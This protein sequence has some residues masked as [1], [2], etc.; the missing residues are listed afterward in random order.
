MLHGHF[1]HVDKP[2]N[3]LAQDDKLWS[4][5]TQDSPHITTQQY[6]PTWSVTIVI[7][8]G[9]P[10]AAHYFNPIDKHPPPVLQWA[11]AHVCGLLIGW[12]AI[13]IG[14]VSVLAMGP[15]HQL[16]S[17][18]GEVGVSI[19][20]DAG[21]DE[22]SKSELHC[23]APEWGLTGCG[24]IQG[25]EVPLEGRDN[26]QLFK[27]VWGGFRW[28]GIGVKCK[29]FLRVEL[30]CSCSRKS[31]WGTGRKKCCCWF[32]K[33]CW[34]LHIHVKYICWSSQTTQNVWH[35][36]YPK[37]T[38]STIESAIRGMKIPHLDH[39][40]YP[41]QCSSPRIIST[42]TPACNVV[43]KVNIDL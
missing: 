1:S 22:S 23:A 9:N 17:L 35:Q 13:P 25:E 39:Q 28:V 2:L 27:F 15:H 12:S 11:G 40:F 24:L 26:G 10:T 38:R 32:L 4:A 3:P 18:D 43:T 42:I 31:S 29:A 16:L 8:H 34:G 30:L 33:T 20:L 19:R 6:R 41:V 21:G 7:G 14:R 37:Q 36:E 5:S